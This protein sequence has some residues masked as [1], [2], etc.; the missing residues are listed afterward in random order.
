M[1]FQHE[2]S[3]LSNK[4]FYF[5]RHGQTD[6]NTKHRAMGIADIPLNH[7]GEKQ[8]MAA[9]LLIKN[10]DINHIFYSP[11]KRAA[12][13]AEIINSDLGCTMTPLDDLREFNLGL[14]AGKVIG[15]W[16]E[17]WMKGKPLPGGELFVD[18]IERGIRGVNTAIKKEGKILIV[19]HGGIYWAI[20]RAINRLDLP[21]LQNCFLA[22]FRSKLERK[23]WECFIK[24]YEKRQVAL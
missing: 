3:P 4:S 18:F 5:I 23:E 16:F 10:K 12:R 19:A 9:Q 1:I 24:P 17:E 20:Q 21:D 14:Y 2:W 6:W 11:L 7:F 15:N 13:T 22:D 8:S